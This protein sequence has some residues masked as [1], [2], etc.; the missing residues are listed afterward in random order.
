MQR[1][2]PRRRS[3]GRAGPRPRRG[4]AWHARRTGRRNAP[5]AAIGPGTTAMVLA[6]LSDPALSRPWPPVHANSGAGVDVAGASEAST[7]ETPTDQKRI[8]EDD[9]R[10]EG[11]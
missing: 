4:P 9:G 10:V 11:T 5:R 8:I 7:A 1:A 6:S 2:P 3:E